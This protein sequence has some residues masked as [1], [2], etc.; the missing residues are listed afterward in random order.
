[1][2]NRNGFSTR[3]TDKVIEALVTDRS[4]YLPN[5]EYLRKYLSL[6][7]SLSP[8]LGRLKFVLDPRP[9]LR[10]TRTAV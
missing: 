3:F 1:M 6:R 9:D 7:Y 5:R 8:K 4:Y 10:I 2:E